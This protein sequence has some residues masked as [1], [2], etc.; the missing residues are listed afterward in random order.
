MKYAC[1]GCGVVFN[2]KEA[3]VRCCEE[4]AVLTSEYCGAE[5]IIGAEISYPVELGEF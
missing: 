5:I 2:N 4:E 3:A 1:A